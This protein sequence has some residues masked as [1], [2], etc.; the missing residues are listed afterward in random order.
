MSISLEE[1]PMSQPTT[2]PAAQ[3][4]AD[5]T[6]V[7]RQFVSFAFYKLDPAFRRLA[8]SE[9]AAAKAEFAAA[10]N[11]KRNGMICLSYSTLAMKADCDFLLWRIGQS[12]DDFQLQEAAMNK[13][14][15]GGYLSQPYSFLSM[16]KRSMYID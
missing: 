8:D 10:I 1:T 14:R 12:A 7:H 5:A 11:E 6:V 15:L 4:P 2:N 13:T 3:P 16:T 9:K